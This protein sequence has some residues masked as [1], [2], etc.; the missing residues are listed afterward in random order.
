MARLIVDTRPMPCPLAFSGDSGDLVWFLSF[1]AVEQYGSQHELSKAATVLRY[2]HKLR[3]RPLVHFTAAD[4]DAED[5]ERHWQAAAPLAETA[6]RVRQA[7]EG[8]DPE[9]RVY[10]QGFPHIAPL[11]ADLEATARWAAEHGCEIR[12]TYEL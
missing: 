9:L 7:L 3:L 6:A 8:D 2:K 4:D 11:L 1:A 10:T 12:L 5:L